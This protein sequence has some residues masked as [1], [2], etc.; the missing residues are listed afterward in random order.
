MRTVEEELLIEDANRKGVNGGNKEKEKKLNELK[1][2]K[3]LIILQEN[4]GAR[5]LIGKL[6]QRNFQL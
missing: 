1:N 6:K 2:N 3:L 4:S 5:Q